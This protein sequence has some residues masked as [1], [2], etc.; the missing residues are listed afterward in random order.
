[1]SAVM[2]PLSGAT[3]HVEG[4]KDADSL[5]MM[6]AECLKV[7]AEF[8]DSSYR[9]ERG[10]RFDPDIELIVKLVA[11]GVRR[12]VTARID[13]EIVAL[14]NWVVVDDIDTRS[15]RV[16]HM[17]GIWKRSPDVCDTVDFIKFGVAAMKASGVHSVMMSAYAGSPGLR[18]K[19]EAAGAKLT[20]YTL[21]I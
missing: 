9:A 19:M 10:I 4:F 12:F 13:G 5:R 3:F 15:R 1:M 14:Q 11:A 7:F 21:E 6:I 18:E 16:A 17:V 2:K 20:D 8:W